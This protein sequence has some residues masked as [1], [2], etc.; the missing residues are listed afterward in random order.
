MKK[1][2]S[3]SVMLLSLLALTS[4]GLMEMDEQVEFPVTELTLD[5][6]TVC[7]MVGDR[8]ALTPVIKPDSVTVDDV[9]WLSSNERV[10]GVEDNVFTAKTAG[11]A[12]VRAISVSQQLEDSCWV[13]VMPR[14]EDNR[15]EYPHEMMVYADVTVDGQPFD[16]ETMMLGAFVEDQ[17]RGIGVL[18]ESN[19]IR[20]VS[21][22]VGSDMMEY[23]TDPDGY[24]E[25]I[26]FRVY[27]KRQLRYKEFPQTI[28]FDG[29]TH[30]TLNRLFELK[31]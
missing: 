3:F 6:D 26:R 11:W 19:G 4:C 21:F 25:T 23:N 29:Q 8:F 13:E 22:R 27:L 5:R 28:E 16:P 18:K 30:G 14:W 24:N 12:L 7:V 20:Y 15:Y 2:K 1:V 31:N 17:L 9:F 10:V